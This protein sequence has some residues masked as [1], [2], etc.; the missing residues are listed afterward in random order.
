LSSTMP[1]DTAFHPNAVVDPTQMNVPIDLSGTFGALLIGLSIGLILWGMQTLQSVWYYLNYPKDPLLLKLWVALISILSTMDI[2]FSFSGIWEGVI[3]MSGTYSS[4]LPMKL[5]YARLLAYGFVG[6]FCQLFFL[7][8][9]FKFAGIRLIKYGIP[10]LLLPLMIYQL[11][12]NIICAALWLRTDPGNN[13]AGATT[14]AAARAW[15]VSSYAVT[16]ATDIIIAL[17][18]G[19]LLLQRRSGDSK[20]DRLL[21]K[22]AV[23]S[24]NTGTWTAVDALLTVILSLTTPDSED[25]FACP[26]WFASPL[27]VNTVFCNLNIRQFFRDSDDSNDTI[28]LSTVG[29]LTSSNWRTGSAGACPRSAANL[30]R[31][32]HWQVEFPRS[33]A[34]QQINQT[35]NN[36]YVTSHIKS[37]E[38]GTISFKDQT[39]V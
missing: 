21:I 39:N 30:N 24:I 2:A 22:I 4:T 17:V 7:Y 27:Y 35:S 1:D 32:K 33:R 6:F 38:E 23:T 20:T 25:I 9:I 19:G 10:A 14:R 8:R 11:V 15:I 16:G 12:A 31:D 5:V 18:M 37:S 36:N 34:D 29:F 26:S 28:W 3:A 13:M